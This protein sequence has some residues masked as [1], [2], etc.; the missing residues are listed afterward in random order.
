MKIAIPATATDLNAS[1]EN[2]LGTAAYL[3][4]IDTDDMSF[5]AM[6]GPPPSTGPG[7]GIQTIATVMGMGA[8]AIL[9]GFISPQIASTLEKNGIEVITPVTGKVV[10]AA[11]TYRQGGFSPTAGEAPLPGEAKAVPMAERLHAA[12][13]KAARQFFGIVPVLTVMLVGG[14]L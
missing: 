9:A 11:E 5:T 14:G 13:Q 1:V 2:R 6:A 4:V 8:T 12:F 3:L 10:D 7:A